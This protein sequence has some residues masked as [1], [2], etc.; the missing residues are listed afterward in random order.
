MSKLVSIAI[1]GAGSR[2]SI[3]AQYALEN[4]DL[5]KVVAVA[6]PREE[7]RKKMVKD[8][9]I[10]NDMVFKSWEDLAK[11]KKLAD[12]V[13]I[14]TQDHM[15]VEP[16]IAFA[17][18]K[19]HI[20]LEKPMAPTEEEC[21]IIVQSAVDNNVL[22][23][24]CHVLR[25][26]QY[27]K[28]LKEVIESGVIG[29]V[30]S[31]QHLEPVAYW[32]QAHSFVR[33]NW[34]NKAK[35]TFMLLAKACHDLDWISYL[36]D[37]PCTG[38]SSFGSL[39]HFKKENQPEG[40]TAYCLDCPKIDSCAYS[41]KKIYLDAFD[42]DCKL[43]SGVHK[44][45]LNIVTPN[46]TRET[47]EE[48][49]RTGDYGR[50]VYQCDNDV[51]DNQVVNMEFTGGKTVSFTMTAFTDYAERRTRIFGTKGMIEGDTFN[52][53]VYDFL[54]D[55]NTN[56]PI[57]I[58]TS[59]MTLH[60]GGDYGIMKSFVSAIKDNDPTQIIS[61]AKATL[62]SHLMVFAAEKSRLNRTIETVNNNLA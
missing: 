52:L 26:T 12:A 40:A 17:N 55:V 35:S 51:V 46:P 4:P 13:I 53:K 24:V 33:G 2:G 45:F 19:Y 23:S 27:T 49:L 6:E 25:Y 21:R 29:D 50:C 3:Y 47:L 54:T 44:G 7:Y 30:V 61:G 8:H 48:A 18:L 58:P 42:A 1:I 32:H 38:V 10:A 15:H 34:N 43:P 39:N 37:T 56:I 59:N 57:D 36:M 9:H 22:F 14:S 20:L 41:A 28:K 62:E 60:G 16:S 11:I 31:M 5:C